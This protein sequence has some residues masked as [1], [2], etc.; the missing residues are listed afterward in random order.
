MFGALRLWPR[1]PRLRA[2]LAADCTQPQDV[3]A[4]LEGA[5]SVVELHARCPHPGWLVY[6]A[7]FDGVRQDPLALGTVELLRDALALDPRAPFDASVLDRLDELPYPELAD[8]VV[9]VLRRA[10]GALVIADAVPTQ[11]NPALFELDL[12]LQDLREEQDAGAYRGAAT[13]DRDT[14][15]AAAYSLG[16]EV[17][18]HRARGLREAVTRRSAATAALLSRALGP[19]F[20]ARALATLRHRYG[21]T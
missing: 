5:R 17:K 9:H 8:L 15:L 11:D 19:S 12:A 7:Y 6:C 14:L 1:R 16:L 20:E 2:A 13:D 3:G 4:W 21:W 10:P 18:A